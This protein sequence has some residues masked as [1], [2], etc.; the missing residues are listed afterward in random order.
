MKLKYT[1][2]AIRDLQS[3]SSYISDVLYNPA[4]ANRIKKSILRACASLKQQPMLGGSVEAKT[5]YE[6]DLRFLICE[7]HLI[8]YRI[9]N[10]EIS[11]SRVIYGRM[12][13]VRILFGDNLE[14]D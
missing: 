6:T 11:V 2:A 4:A 12:D 1:P 8:F 14:T 3:M 13:Y 5:G 7:R 9:E 10:D